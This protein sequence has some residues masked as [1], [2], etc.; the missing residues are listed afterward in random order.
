M[1]K[2]GSYLPYINTNEDNDLQTLK[3]KT[4][5][6]SRSNVRNYRGDC[7]LVLIVVSMD[8][9]SHLKFMRNKKSKMALLYMINTLWG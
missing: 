5:H 8:F 2:G 6:A 3:H 9:R 7:C 4:N 1:K